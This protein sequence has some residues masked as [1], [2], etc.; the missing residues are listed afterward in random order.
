MTIA[1]DAALDD[2]LAVTVLTDLR[3]PLLVRT[4][5]SSIR[6]AAYL[7][8]SSRIVQVGDVVGVELSAPSPFPWQVDGDDLGDVDHL[9]VAYRPDCLTL[10]TP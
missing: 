1:P 2:A 4:A 7:G 5:A 6:R 10:V 9:S 8:T 3:A